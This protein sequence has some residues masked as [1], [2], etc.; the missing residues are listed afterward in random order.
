[1]GEAM[2]Q[3]S[4]DRTRLLDSL[5]H[6]RRRAAEAM[7]GSPEWEAAVAGVEELETA[8]DAL[9]VRAPATSA[10][11]LPGHLVVTFGPHVLADR[12]IVQ[13]TVAGRARYAEAVCIAAGDIARRAATRREFA[14]ELE[15]LVADWGFVLEV[16][17]GPWD[18]FTFYAWDEQRVDRQT[19]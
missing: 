4:N 17:S 13:G 19:D 16:S 12:Q 10:P 6:A 11:S 5:E 14:R 7:R 15:R 18:A 9:E 1:M 3:P 8:L 2:H